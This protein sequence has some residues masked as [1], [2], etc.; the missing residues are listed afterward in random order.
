MDY[1]SFQPGGQE[2]QSH[3]PVP[4][5]P[6]QALVTPPPMESVPRKI[7][8][9]KFIGVVALLLVLGAGAYAGIWYWQNQQAAQEIVPTFTPRPSVSVTPTPDT[10]TWKT[11]TNTQYGF[12]IKYPNDFEVTKGYYDSSLSLAKNVVIGD[13]KSKCLTDG[14]LEKLKYFE[15][16]DFG[17]INQNQTA[18]D[19]IIDEYVYTLSKRSNY[20]SAI[21]EKIIN[22]TTSYQFTSNGGYI[23]KDGSGGVAAC[24]S[25]FIYL[26]TPKGK[27]LEIYFPNEL[28]FNQILS[29]FKF[30]Q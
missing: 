21:E 7:F 19:L 3:G 13:G 5:A 12:E 22:D 6:I 30:T 17:N 29:T 4:Q 16:N 20:L 28:I 9:P 24:P 26:A 10:S 11:Y 27:G 18:K 25:K 2:Q 23:Y 15:I 14:G 8:T 1:S